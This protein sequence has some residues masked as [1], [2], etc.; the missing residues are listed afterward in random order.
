MR[1]AAL[2]RDPGADQSPSTSVAAAGILLGYGWGKPPQ[3]H[4]GED[5]EG[6]IEI[7]V[8]HITEGKK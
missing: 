4:T 8:R 7:T 5:G 1:L 2:M 3:P 6:A